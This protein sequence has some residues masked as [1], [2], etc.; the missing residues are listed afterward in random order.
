MAF[1][2]PSEI[3]GSTAANTD[4]KEYSFKKGE[5][6]EVTTTLTLSL[7]DHLRL[8]VPEVPCDIADEVLLRR[9]VEYFL[10]ES[11]R[12]LKVHFE[13]CILDATVTRSGI[14]MTYTR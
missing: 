5:I 2:M 11:A 1:A 10:P 9:F 12:L 8:H 7:Q 4:T 14:D 13:R 3:S 6:L